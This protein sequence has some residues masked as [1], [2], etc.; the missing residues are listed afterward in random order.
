MAG[1]KGYNTEGD[2]LVNQTADGVNLNVLWAEI[3]DALALY[4]SQRSTVVRLLSYPTIAVADVIAQSVEGESFEQATEFGIPRAIRE[5]A[6]YLRLGYNFRDYDKALRATWKFLRE[7]TADQVTAQIT[8]I[9]ESDNRLVTGTIMN[10]LLNPAIQ[11]NEWSYSCYGL[12]NADGMV[13]PDYLGNSFT[14]THTH[15]LTSGSAV[16]DSQDIEDMLH[17][18]TEHGYGRL[19]NQGGQLIILANPN[20]AQN[21]TYWRAGIDYGG[22]TTPR[23]DFIPSTLLP[24]FFTTEHLIGALPPADF[25]GL[26]VLGSYGDSWLIESHYMSAGYVIVC[27]SGGLDSDLNPVGVRHH[28]NP[29]YQGL[30][31]IPGNGPYPLVESFFARGFGVG[32]GHRGAAVVM[33]VTTSATYTPPVVPV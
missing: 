5:P 33:Q 31:H 27:A 22:A 19:G 15:Y 8:R 25:N 23:W 32:V 11:T 20:D 14:G 13:P 2:V 16:I 29:A 26:Q 6:D 18:V 3:R 21:M 28:I 7:A 30:R 24:A 10:R 4:N 1:T 12:W 9:F 17:H